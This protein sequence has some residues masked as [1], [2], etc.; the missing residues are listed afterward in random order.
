MQRTPTDAPIPPHGAVSAPRRGWGGFVF[1]PG[2]SGALH[3][4]LTG[5]LSTST[6]VQL[7]LAVRRASR[8]N[9][10]TFVLLRAEAL[11]H[12]SLS[13]AHALLRC[14]RDWR[15][16][17]AVTAWVAPSPYVAKLLALAAGAEGLPVLPDLA[18]A[19]RVA[20]ELGDRPP[21]VARD[22]LEV[23]STPAH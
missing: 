6:V 3:V 16:W 17:G 5:M 15:Q 23:W 22:R 4:K 19:Q 14:E 12:V 8:G 10:T 21:G 20:A 2:S 9:A 13:A 1:A 18:T 7:D 11:T